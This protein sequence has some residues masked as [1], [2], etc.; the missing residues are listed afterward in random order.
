MRM[1]GA[2]YRRILDVRMNAV[3]YDRAVEKIMQWA[4]EAQSRYVCALAVHGVMEAHDDLAVRRAVN[5]S[6][7][8][9]P[10]G[11]PVVWALRRLKARSASRVYGPELTLR[12]LSAA[13]RGGIPVGLYGGSSRAA[14]THL[15]ELIEQRFPGLRVAYASSPRHDPVTNAFIRPTEA[16]EAD[17]VAAIHASGTRILFVGLGC[18]R[19]ELWMASHRNIAVVKV[20]V[21]A[22]FDFIAGTKPQAPE[23]LQ[24]AGLEWLFRLSTEPRRLWKRYLKHNPRYAALIVRQILT[25]SRTGP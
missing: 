25:D 14:T 16:E 21:G 15:A 5:G 8:N 3:G 19:Q 18:P 7:M 9:V 22:A 10:D 20:G 4:G 1:F 2:E 11:M 12:T 17:L 23:L 6:D 24:R 13:S